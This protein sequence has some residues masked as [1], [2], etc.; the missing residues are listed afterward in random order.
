VIL[1][2]KAVKKIPETKD[3]YK[4][5][6]ISAVDYCGKRNLVAYVKSFADEE[7]KCYIQQVILKDLN[8]GKERV[9]TANGYKEENPRFSPDGNKLAF[10]SNVTGDKQIWIF[11]LNT[12]K[13]SRLTSMRYGASN[14]VW[15]PLGDKI[16]FLSPKPSGESIYLLQKMRDPKELDELKEQRKRQPIVIEN[17][18]FKNE[19]DMGFS[20][21]Q[22][23]Q[24][25]WIVDINTGATECLTDGDKNH[26]MP[27]WFPDGKRLLFVSNRD[28]ANVEYLAQDLYSVDIETKEIKRITD[29]IYIAYYPK[30]IVPK[31]TPDGKYVI[32]G[33]LVVDSDGYPPVHLYKVCLETGETTK[34]FNDDAPCE[35]ATRFL[36]NADS[37][38]EVYDTMQVSSDGEYAYFIAGWHGKGNIYRVNIN[39]EPHVEEFTHGKQNYGSISEVFNGKMICVKC[40]AKNFYDIW[41][42]DEKTKHETR[43]T[44]SNPWLEERLISDMEELWIDTLDGKARVQ[45]WVIKPQLAKEGEKYPAV[46]YIHGGPTP[47]YGYALCYEHQC[48]AGQGIG[49]I[50]VNPRGSSGYGSEHSNMEQ[51]F[52]GTAY[53]DLLQFVDEAV[54]HFDWIDG[55]RLGVCGGSYGGY[56]TNWIASHSKRFKAAATHRSLANEL[57]SYASSDMAGSPGS[58][59]YAAFSDFMIDKLKSSPIIYSENINMPFLILHSINDMRCPVENAHQL[60]TAIKDLHPDLPVR[61]VLFP[62][63]NHDLLGEGPMYLRIIHYNE[64]IEWFKKYL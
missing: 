1:M 12:G 50:L 57:F 5:N 6:Y 2:S 46:L 43:L 24:H 61:M 11:D 63:S 35:G 51:A 16:A 31:F 49:V 48:M 39:G 28:R 10:L 52:D 37:Y 33:G 19:K 55:N 60:F 17:F 32:V 34:I 44:N 21:P 53:Y 45:G 15:S 56:M 7:K 25:V 14:I 23:S 4:I 64:N 62:N 30:K 3:F 29:S 8:S 59:S 58:K 54:K 36:Y 27:V 20:T 22:S 38:G 47:Y 26:V 40:D 42:L 18:G 41:M 9:I 13:L